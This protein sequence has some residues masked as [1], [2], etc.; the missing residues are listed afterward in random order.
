MKEEPRIHNGERT[1]ASINSAGKI[2]Q[3]HTG[4][5]AYTTKI[6]S[7]WIRDLN[8]RHETVKILEE[9]RQ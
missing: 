3:P 2:G 6:N 9:N 4:S 7:K 8:V 5:L 1:V